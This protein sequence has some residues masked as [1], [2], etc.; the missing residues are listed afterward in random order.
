MFV[1]LKCFHTP[2]PFHLKFMIIFVTEVLKQNLE[3]RLE[4]PLWSRA[5]V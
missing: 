2:F 1:D 4:L 3:G 5:G